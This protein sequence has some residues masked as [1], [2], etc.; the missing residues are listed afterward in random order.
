MPLY[1]ADLQSSNFSSL[2]HR[3]VVRR[4]DNHILYHIQLHH[5]YHLYYYISHL[6]NSD[7]HVRSCNRNTPAL[8]QTEAI[9][10]LRMIYLCQC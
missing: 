3:K 2:S 4:I 6:Q 9:S 10:H 1:S 7:I 5:N 8:K